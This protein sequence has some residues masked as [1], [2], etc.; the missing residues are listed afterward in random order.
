MISINLGYILFQILSLNL[1]VSLSFLS[2][3]I[4]SIKN[5]Y[6]FSYYYVYSSDY[7]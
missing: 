3:L 2:F 6:F 7:Y 1:F 5:S 4:I